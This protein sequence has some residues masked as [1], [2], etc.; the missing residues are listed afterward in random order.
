MLVDGSTASSAV[1]VN[2]GGTLGGTGTTGPVTAA[3][4]TVNPSD[5]VGSV[6]TLNG[7]SASFSGNGNL[8]VEVSGSSTLGT[9]SADLLKLSGALTL[10]GTST[11]TLDLAGL[12]TSTAAPVAI[13]QDGGQ[14]GT[15]NTVQVINN[16]LNLTP[17]I[18][19]TGNAVLVAL[20]GTPSHVAFTAGPANTSAGQALGA[21][22]VQVAV[23][24][25]FGNGG[26]QR[27][28]R[29]GDGRHCQWAGAAFTGGS[30]TTATVS[31]GVTTFSQPGIRLTAEYV[32]HVE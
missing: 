1:T 28:R 12:T 23:E 29:H 27:Q 3:G 5:P 6:G 19:Y 30:A 13:V 32:A 9:I 18:T 26:Q 14:T 7:S 24:D 22:N 11:L 15:F 21:G 4:G 2:A 17:V 25:Q 16:P 31:G 20:V 8:T 10:G